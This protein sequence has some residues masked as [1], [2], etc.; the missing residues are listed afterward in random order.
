MNIDELFKEVSMLNYRLKEVISMSKYNYYDDLSGVDY[1]Y[2]NPDQLFLLDEMRSLLSKL[3]DVS[4]TIDYLGKPIKVE[5]TLHKQAN[6]RYAVG[7]YELSSGHGLEYLTSNDDFHSKYDDESD[8]YINYPYWIA[9]RV[10][11]NGTDYYIVG[12][13][14]DIELEGLQVRIRG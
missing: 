3:D 1:D 7:N 8:Q 9:S 14:K 13:S 11:H 12:A 6:G 5:G 4:Y 10:E 2:K